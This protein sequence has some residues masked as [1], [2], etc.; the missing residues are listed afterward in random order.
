MSL[1][2]KRFTDGIHLCGVYLKVRIRGCGFELVYKDKLNTFLPKNVNSYKQSPQA[3]DF[4]IGFGE[5]Y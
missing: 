2:L 5:T 4:N 3:F 1:V